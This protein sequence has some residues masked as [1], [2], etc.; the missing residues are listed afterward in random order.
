MKKERLKYEERVEAFVGINNDKEIGGHISVQ[1]G[2]I[3]P[4]VVMNLDPP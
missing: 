3:D 2:K 4:A 1:P